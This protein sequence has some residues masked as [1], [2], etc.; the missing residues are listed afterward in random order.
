MRAVSAAP[1]FGT[2]AIMAPLEGLKTSMVELLSAF[3][4]RPS[5]KALRRI[6]DISLSEISMSYPKK[7]EFRA[8]PNPKPTPTTCSNTSAQDTSEANELGNIA[9]EI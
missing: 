2:D 3:T 6:S 4:Q 1:Q 9:C 5:M 7:T 8:Y